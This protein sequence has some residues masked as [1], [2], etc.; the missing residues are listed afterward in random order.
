MVKPLYIVF[1]F[2]ALSLCDQ[3]CVTLTKYKNGDLTC[4]KEDGTNPNNTNDICNQLSTDQ[5]DIRQNGNGKE[6]QIDP[7]LKQ[8]LNLDKLKTNNSR[9][10]FKNI[11]LK[12]TGTGDD[13]TLE[14]C[15]ELTDTIATEDT[16]EQSDN[17]REPEKEEEQE[18]EEEINKKDQPLQNGENYGDQ[19]VLKKKENNPLSNIFLT[20]VDGLN[21]KLKDPLIMA[22]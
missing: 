22:I 6:T 21:Q 8:I 16:V 13:E 2:F 4:K 7:K 11:S 9:V 10:K 1:F 14:L 15:Y 12:L 5:K 19:R 18:Q 17:E 20:A 3:M